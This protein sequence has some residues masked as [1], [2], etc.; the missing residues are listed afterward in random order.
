MS[1]PHC[2]AA[3]FMG[4]LLVAQCY[5][6]EHQAYSQTHP[7]ND[8]I[9]FAQWA[10]KTS[11]SHGRL[12]QGAESGNEARP[13]QLRI[14]ASDQP[15]EDQSVRAARVKLMGDKLLAERKADKLSKRVDT[16]E[17]GLKQKEE[18]LAQIRAAAKEGEAQ[19]TAL[20]EQLKGLQDTEQAR[21]MEVQSKLTEMTARL[22]E[23]AEES[24]RLKKELGESQDLLG[25][26]KTAIADSSRLKDEAEGELTKLRT[27]IQELQ[28]QLARVSADAEQ[29]KQDN[30]NLQARMKQ[31]AKDL[32]QCK[33]EGKL[34]K[35]Q[36][37]QLATQSEQIR[38]AAEQLQA[39]RD[40]YAQE[41]Q[42]LR[43]QLKNLSSKITQTPQT[44]PVEQPP[45]V[46]QPSSRV[47]PS[48]VVQQPPP[49]EE[50]GASPIDRML[51][52][53]PKKKSR[54][55]GRKKQDVNL[56]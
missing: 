53:P 6:Q 28:S 55:K 49:A 15:A 47:Q 22:Q 23:R 7:Q 48:P 17:Q 36:L 27:R 19:V 1:F 37:G 29:Y 30:N 52:V 24:K 18:E 14:A 34:T 2:R 42:S 40:R 51:Q 8:R 31:S 43:S 25:A 45:L 46:E 32:E 21:G 11:W 26:L 20:T 35:E 10:S 3:I 4:L 56:F 16:L 54:Q 13:A 33:T 38:E 9:R 5:V 39:D 41:I 44:P 12:C 50:E